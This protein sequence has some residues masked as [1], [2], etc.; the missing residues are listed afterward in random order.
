MRS[1]ERYH[2]KSNFVNLFSG[3]V[4]NGADDQIMHLQSI[5]K[6]NLNGSLYVQRRW[7]SCGVKHN[8]KHTSRLTIDYFAFE[9]MILLSLSELSKEDYTGGFKPNAERTKLLKAIRAYTNKEN[10]LQEELIATTSKRTIAILTKAMEATED[11]R[12]KCE[13]EYDIL[14]NIQEPYSGRLRDVNEI[15]KYFSSKHNEELDINTRYQLKNIL[16]TIIKK[17]IVYPYKLKNRTVAAKIVI[18]LRSNR[19]R[20]VILLKQKQ[21]KDL[22]TITYYSKRGK[23]SVSISDSGMV[24][25]E[26]VDDGGIANGK[27]MLKLKNCPI[28]IDGN[29]KKLT[30]DFTQ[31]MILGSFLKWHEEYFQDA[32]TQGFNFPDP[33]KLI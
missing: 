28:K 12:L 25:W 2:E 31:Y 23:P 6:D 19:V 10:Q 29:D 33:F 16:P 1:K 4:F 3:L 26:V 27:D 8:L 13:R 24:L 9:K 32:S 7:Q 17:I 22:Q 11:K 30:C 21:N 20:R 18:L 5:K 15:P 14:S